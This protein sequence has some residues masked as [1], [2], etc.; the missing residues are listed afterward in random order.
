[1]AYSSWRRTYLGL[2]RVL[3]VGSSFK[4]YAKMA[5]NFRPSGSGMH[6]LAW[7]ACNPLG[8]FAHLEDP[9]HEQTRPGKK[10]QLGK[11]WGDASS[12]AIRFTT[13]RSMTKS[14]RDG[15][16]DLSRQKYHI[17]VSYQLPTGHSL[18]AAD[19]KSMR[20]FDR[21][22]ADKNGKEINAKRDLIFPF[23]SICKL[24]SNESNTNKCELPQLRLVGPRKPRRANRSFR[25]G[26]AV[27]VANQ[28]PEHSQENHTL[29][30]PPST[31]RQPTIHLAWTPPSTLKDASTLPSPR[32]S[33]LQQWQHMAIIRPPWCSLQPERG[34]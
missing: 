9:S 25:R 8:T 15:K 20:R 27:A 13:T 28:L 4:I 34:K 2:G 32:A 10:G 14:T 16:L 1:M 31:H 12:S 5:Q 26:G 24:S 30:H 19:A 6:V 29:H 7:V 17:L 22:P 3:V 33:P 23:P 21:V 11:N 18:S